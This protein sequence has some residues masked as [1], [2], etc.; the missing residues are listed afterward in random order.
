MWLFFGLAY[1]FTWG[2]QLPAV[3]ARHGVISGPAEAWLPLTGLGAFGPM[4]AAIICVWREPRGVRALFAQLKVW[5]VGPL[6]YAVALGCSGALFVAGMALASLFGAEGPWFYPPRDAPHLVA[7]VVFSFGEEVGW[8]GYA[9]PRLQARHGAVVASAVIGVAWCFWH[10]LMFDL[11]GISLWVLAMMLPFFVAGSVVFTWVWNRG[12]HSLL[13]MVLA[14]LG[15]HLN[16]SNQPLPGN[17]V[18]ALVHSAAFVAFALLLLAVD[19]RH[20]PA[21]PLG[22]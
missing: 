16:N 11:T 1:T 18:P 15:A 3:L 20:L 22:P 12:R 10:A 4:L 14:H 9:L 5:R 19:R 6:W 17:A 2:A 7:A 8:R 13:L 21:R